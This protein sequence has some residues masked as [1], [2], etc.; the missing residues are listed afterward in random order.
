MLKTLRRCC[1][2]ISS[3]AGLVAAQAALDQRVD[4]VSGYRRGIRHVGGP[5]TVVPD[6][7]SY[8]PPRRPGRRTGRAADAMNRGLMSAHATRLDQRRDAPSRP[9]DRA[10]AAAVGTPCYVYDAAAIRAAYRRSTTR[11]TAIRTP[12]T[13]RSRPTRRWRSCA[14]LRALGS[15]ADANSLGEVDVALRCGFRPDRD[16]LHRRR[17]ERRRDRS[18]GGAR[19]AGHQR[20]IAGRARSH[21]SARRSRRARW[22]ASRCASTPTSTRRAIRTSRP[23]SSRT[24]SACRS[25]RRRRC[26]A[27]WRR[28]AALRPVGVH[29]HIGSQITTLDPLS[30]RRRSRRRARARRCAARA[31]SSQHLDI[32]GGLGISYDGGAGRRS[33]RRTCARWSRRRA[34]AA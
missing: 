18:R 1:R 24:S 3:H 20:R 31:S 7:E 32:G 22:R 29:V 19:P 33:G 15:D 25:T 28:A 13:T 17:Q 11:S 9:A 26:F 6:P 10:I 5:R 14:L 16:R 30:T 23:A 34:A 8:H 12:S 21:R 27:R 4:G 2:T